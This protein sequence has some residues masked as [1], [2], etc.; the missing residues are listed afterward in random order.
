MPDLGEGGGSLRPPTLGVVQ[1]WGSP[2][3]LGGG[4]SCSRSRSRSAFC[5]SVPPC[6]Q[7]WGFLCQRLL[8]LDHNIQYLSFLL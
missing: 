8:W 5:G 7:Q 1:S 2:P 4:C 6:M 3:R